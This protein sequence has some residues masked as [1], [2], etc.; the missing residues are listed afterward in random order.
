MTI[1]SDLNLNCGEKRMYVL[2]HRVVEMLLYENDQASVCVYTHAYVCV[3]TYVQ[4][5]H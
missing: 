5:I 2:Y 3:I 1:N 4:E